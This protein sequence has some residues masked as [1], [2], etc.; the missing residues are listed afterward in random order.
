[1]YIDIMDIT[2]LYIP[3]IYLRV[4][5]LHGHR[6]QKTKKTLI[7]QALVDLKFNE[8]FAFG[9][10]SKH[11]DNSSLALTV[12]TTCKSPLNH[13]VEYGRIVLGSFMYAR[14][15]ELL[16]WQEMLM[17]PSV[18]VSRWHHIGPSLG[19]H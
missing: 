17:Q 7:H 2:F 10:S 1:M 18:V 3:G 8:T 16:H 14:G 15:E 12:L 9:V 19:S 11:L 6:V 5:F 13:D 4:Q